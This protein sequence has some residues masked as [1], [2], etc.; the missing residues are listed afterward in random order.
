MTRKNAIFF[1]LDGMRYDI[2]AD[3][4]ALAFM[5]PNIA[6]VALRGFVRKV[7]TNAQATQFVMP[8][9]FTLTYPLDF[10]GYNDGI[11]ERPK[12]FV[13]LLH[14]NGYRTHLFSTCN[15]M[16]LSNGYQRG[17]DVIGSTSDYRT[18]LEH[19]IARGISYWLGLWK[20]GQMSDAE[21]IAFLQRDFGQLLEAMIEALDTHDK[22]IWPPKLMRLNLWIADRCK[23]ELQ[24]LKT[25]PLTVARKLTRVAP[26]IYWHFLGA[27]NVSQWKLFPLR[28]LYSI[29][30]RSRKALGAQL[31]IPFLRI[32]NYQAI[33]GEVV[34]RMAAAVRA[35]PSEPWFVHMHTMDLH[36][37]RAINRPVHVIGRLRYF[38]RWLRARSKG[39]TKRRFLYDSAL[40][41]A[42]DCFG[43]LLDDLEKSGKLDNTVILITGDHGSQFAEGPRLKTAIG[44]RMH[45]E[46]VEVPLIMFGTEPPPTG[47]Q[48]GL[49]DSRA[50]TAS[51]L[52][53]LSIK[54]HPTFATTTAFGPGRDVV[55]SECCGAG[56]ADLKR[57]DIYF[58]VTSPTHRMFATLKG[59]EF[60][61][62]RLWD[63]RADPREVK[64]IVDASEHRPVIAKLVRRLYEERTE[65]FH[66]RGIHELPSQ[67][68]DA[69]SSRTS[70][71]SASREKVS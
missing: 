38:G 52:H 51:F 39:L 23:D 54:G 34:D 60:L 15:Q 40:M 53:A 41:Y 22:S 4:K 71:V 8:S 62:T 27:K 5:A 57:R 70:G 26:G 43:M 29:D 13:E 56:A 68:H 45:Y 67:A 59:E 17:F 30:W 58:G 32:G 69:Q 11:R 44:E 25:E 63:L 19:R 24:L 61:V 47:P 48:D 35:M 12:S 37:C 28:V 20:K 10:G 16:G 7:I 50:V 31:I 65:L 21:I 1:I 2:A 42:D 33:F 49:L 6:R 9:L 36:D 55:I 66:L 14:E 46:D 64:N 3:P 18:Q